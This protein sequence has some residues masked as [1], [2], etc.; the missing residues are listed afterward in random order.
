ML[1]VTHMFKEQDKTDG[2]SD[3]LFGFQVFLR[4]WQQT[5]AQCCR[6]APSCGWGRV[7]R[8]QGD[9]S[10]PLMEA[11]HIL[12]M[13]DKVDEEMALSQLEPYI[14]SLR[15]QLEQ[16]DPVFLIAIVVALA[17]VVI[18]CGKKCSF[19]SMLTL[20]SRARPNGLNIC[21]LKFA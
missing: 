10:R 18:T 11:E 3:T 4:L 14:E 19:L 8:R 17:V 13:G 2:S 7:W 12:S 9:V 15:Q 16:Q 6:T 1:I 20:A 21:T 5:A